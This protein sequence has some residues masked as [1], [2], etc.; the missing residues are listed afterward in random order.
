MLSRENI[1][2]VSDLKV[3]P[4]DVPEWGGVVGVRALTGAERDTLE[5][6]MRSRGED[7]AETRAIVVALSCCN[8]AGEPI[9]SLNDIATLQKKNAVALDRI[10]KVS[11]SI[12]LLSPQKV[13]A[14]AKN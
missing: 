2:E 3:T 4:V 14:E 10:F 13:E 7:T 11:A 8:D 6:L 1:V 9:F 12:N 5:K